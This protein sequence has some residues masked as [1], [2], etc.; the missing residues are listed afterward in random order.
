MLICTFKHKDSADVVSMR[1]WMEVGTLLSLRLFL[2]FSVSLASFVMRF[3][4]LWSLPR[5]FL[6]MT[7]LVAVSHY[8]TP[9][10]GGPF[11]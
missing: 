11:S 6:L 10:P 8:R 9:A 5:S 1:S 7:S 3:F 4:S 2:P